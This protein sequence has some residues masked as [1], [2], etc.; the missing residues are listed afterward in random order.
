MNN[1][2]SDELLKRWNLEVGSRQCWWWR[3]WWCGD[4]LKVNLFRG[5]ESLT[6]NDCL[7]HIGQVCNHILC[8]WS[9][10][11]VLEGGILILVTACGIHCE[12]LVDDS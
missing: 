7:S 4:L 1:E 10:D 5:G 9:A 12:V 2:G 11:E 6:L 8:N 3:R